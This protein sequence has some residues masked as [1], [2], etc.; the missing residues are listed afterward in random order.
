[1]KLD[2]V[3]E[4]CKNCINLKA[5]AIR[6]DGNHDYT[7]MRNPQFGSGKLSQCKDYD[8]K[9]IVD[10][11]LSMDVIDKN[12]NEILMHMNFEEENNESIW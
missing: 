7:C 12:T 1:M 4:K 6:T 10:R 9:Y 2:R 3:C 8:P 11:I 5:Y